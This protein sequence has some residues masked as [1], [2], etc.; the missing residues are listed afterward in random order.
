MSDLVN[1]KAYLVGNDTKSE[2]S[3]VRRFSLEGSVSTSLEALKAKLLSGIFPEL[4]RKNIQV[5]KIH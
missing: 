2:A 5:R 1:F 4:R 3:E